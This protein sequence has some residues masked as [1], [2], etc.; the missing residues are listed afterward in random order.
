MAK[1]TEA[2]ASLLGW[3]ARRDDGGKGVRF[4]PQNPGT[5]RTMVSLLSKGLVEVATGRTSG[6][7]IAWRASTAGRAALKETL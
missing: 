3:I 4:L 6:K 2:Q 5:P 1:L 7:T